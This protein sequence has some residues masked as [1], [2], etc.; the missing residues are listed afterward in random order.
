MLKV[1]P[2]SVITDQN[3]VSWKHQNVRD[4]AAAAAAA[5]AQSTDGGFF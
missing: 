3:V 5:A 2:D 4:M 1:H